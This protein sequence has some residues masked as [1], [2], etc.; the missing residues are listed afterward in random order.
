LILS[1]RR[2]GQK[3]ELVVQVPENVTAAKM[4]FAAA[5]LTGCMFNSS[6]FAVELVA[7]N[8]VK[9][10]KGAEALLIKVVLGVPAPTV[11]PPVLGVPVPVMVMP[12]PVTVIPDAQVQEPAGI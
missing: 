11:P 12:T 1:T 7:V 10:K 8:P 5:P 6:T 2:L 3:G 9:V 4:L